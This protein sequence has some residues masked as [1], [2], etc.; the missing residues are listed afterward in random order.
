MTQFT[1]HFLLLFKFFLGG[2]SNYSDHD[3]PTLK[4]GL[5]GFSYFSYYFRGLTSGWSAANMSSLAKNEEV[6]FACPTW[7]YG[8]FVRMLISRTNAYAG[9]GRP[10]LNFDECFVL[11]CSLQFRQRSHFTLCQSGACRTVSM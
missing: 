5:V 2:G 9:C 3:A 11:G 10:T 1:L 7:L 8:L 4:M 6:C